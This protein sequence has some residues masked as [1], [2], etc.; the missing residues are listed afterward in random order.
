MQQFVKKNVFIYLKME[1]IIEYVKGFGVGCRHP[2]D[3]FLKEA[4]DICQPL[5][6]FGISDFGEEEFYHKKFGFLILF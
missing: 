5:K 3:P 2:H 1:N 4:N 6:T